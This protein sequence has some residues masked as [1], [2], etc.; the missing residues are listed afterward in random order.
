MAVWLGLVGI[1]LQAALPLF[2][3]FALASADRVAIADGTLS[4]IHP[5]HGDQAPAHPRSPPAQHTLHINCVLSQGH[6][7]AGPA[8]LPAA[9]V[10]LSPSSNP[11]GRAPRATTV[12]YVLGSPAFYVSRAPPSTV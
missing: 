8:T 6:H 9:I 12:H 11:G 2:L 3:A 1:G 4:A 7:Q 5:D 10:L